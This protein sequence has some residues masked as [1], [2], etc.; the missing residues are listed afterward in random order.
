MST[1]WLKNPLALFDGLTELTSAGIVIQDH[2]IIEVLN[3]NDFMI[4]DN[5]AS[6][7]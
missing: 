2:K 4:L 5:N 1:I 6:T 7:G 3:A